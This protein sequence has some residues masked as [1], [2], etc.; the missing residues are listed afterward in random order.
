MYKIKKKSFWWN[1]TIFA[2]QK[3]NTTVGS[4]IYVESDWDQLD[5]WTQNSIIKHEKT[6]VAQQKAFGFFRFIFLYLFCLPFLYN[7]FRYK[8]EYEAYKNQGLVDQEIQ[9]I[10]KSWQYGWLILNSKKG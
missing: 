3:N 5:E 8:W 7:P 9:S 6:H 2:N 10:L 1:L 4:T